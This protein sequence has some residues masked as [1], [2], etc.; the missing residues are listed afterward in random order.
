[1]NQLI[2][3]NCLNLALDGK[4]SFPETVRQMKETGVER[5]YADLVTLQKI[6]YSPSG[7]VMTEPMPR[8]TNRPPSHSNSHPKT[9]SRQSRTVSRV[10]FNTANSYA[11]S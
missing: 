4:M 5:Y 10:G 1:M 11:A 3:Q 6:H 9:F 8:S 7:E 2:L